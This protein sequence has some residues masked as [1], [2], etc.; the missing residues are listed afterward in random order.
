VKRHPALEQLSRDHHHALVV[1]QALSRADDA[2]A[3][4][5]GDGFL[6]Y[7]QS[8]G[9]ECVRE[10]EEILLP[11]C[12]AF[13]DADHPLIARVLTD[14]L[15]I[16]HLADRL[17]SDDDTRSTYCTTSASGSSATSAWRSETSSPSSKTCY[18]SPSCASCSPPSVADKAA[19]ARS[20]P[21][22]E[23]AAG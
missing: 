21:P 7:W 20:A 9:R 15:R 11:A 22:S 23:G 4:I 18:L 13:M 1:A 14:H 10:E 16:R 6:A 8:D 5:A 12:A 17:A 19:T 2:S 3:A